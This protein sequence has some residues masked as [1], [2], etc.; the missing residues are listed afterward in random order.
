MLA[1]H[2]WPCTMLVGLQPY[3]RD[4]SWLLQALRIMP[5]YFENVLPALSAVS[6]A[7]H[8][9]ARARAWATPQPAPHSH[10]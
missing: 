5:S 1:M 8:A 9:S 7:L 2:R 3:A 10:L 6:P 4:A